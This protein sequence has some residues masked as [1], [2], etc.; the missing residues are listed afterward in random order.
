MNDP[1]PDSSMSRTL[2]ILLILLAWG[3]PLSAQGQIADRKLKDVRLVTFGEQLSLEIIVEPPL[4]RAPVINHEVGFLEVVLDGVELDKPLIYY[5][6]SQEGHLIRSIR[7]LQNTQSVRLDVILSQANVR[8]DEQISLEVSNGNWRVIMP[9]K[10]LA[11]SANTTQN[12]NLA[13]EVEER[14]KLGGTFPSTFE[15]R[16]TTQQPEPTPEDPLL[17]PQ[18]TSSSWMLTGASVILSLLFIFFLMFLVLFFYNR[19]MTGKLSGQKRHGTIKVLNTFHIGAKQ[20]VVVIQAQ[21]KVFACGVT[22]SSITFLSDLSSPTEQNF[23]DQMT[24]KNGKVDFDATKAKID[25]MKT[26]QAARKHTQQTTAQSD[27]SGESY[28]TSAS[29]PGSKLAGNP[30][31]TTSEPQ[32]SAERA[33]RATET[34]QKFSSQG[35]SAGE[36]RQPQ[37]ALHTRVG[38]P[39]VAETNP[40]EHESFEGDPAM[41]QF[42]KV[43]TKKIKSLK[44]IN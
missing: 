8:L 19:F 14:L 13:G 35:K 16:D 5:D 34:Q 33:Q 31:P 3:L 30:K 25:F 18:T 42:S 7:A 10:V 43:L 11:Q 1:H 36:I 37:T 2:F 20:K 9:Q 4:Q 39:V 29:N 32:Q 22:P 12:T 23:M 40:T 28:S 21:N 41:D 17:G 24:F 27:Q 44:P 15:E 6:F 38:D 26:L